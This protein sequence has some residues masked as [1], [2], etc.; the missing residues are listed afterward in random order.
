MTPMKI[1]SSALAAKVAAVNAANAEA[2][3]LHPILSAVFAPLIGSKIEK[4]DG[5]LLESVKKLMPALPNTVALSVFRSPSR[6]SLVWTVKAC[7]SYDGGTRF[8]NGCI[9]HETSCYIGELDGA[10]LKALVPFENTLKGV[11]TDWTENEVAA[12]RAKAE[13]TKKAASEALSALH[14]FGEY[15]R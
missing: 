6:Y 4:V 5:P 11:R 2:I 1:H 8:T 13:A 12:L 9:Y 15:D 7:E 14:P 10:I 3:R